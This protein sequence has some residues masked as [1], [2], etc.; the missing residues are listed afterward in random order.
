[1]FTAI[2]VAMVGVYALANFGVVDMSLVWINPTFM[3]AQVVGGFLLGTGFIM[4]GLCPGTSVVSAAS[5]RWDA[6]VTIGGIFAGTSLFAVAVDFVPGMDALYH[7]G[8]MGVSTLPAVVGMPPLVLTLV[9]VVVAGIAFIAAEKI[10]ARFHGRRPEIELA[11]RPRPRM[12][13]ATAATLAAATLLGLG[14]VWLPDAQP[15]TPTIEAIAALDLAE[16][17]IAGDPTLLII[18]VRSDDAGDRTRIPGAYPAPD[19]ETL[20]GLLQSAP[21]GMQVILHGASHETEYASAGWPSRL[22]YAYI[23]G[24]F[25][26][27]SADV[28]RPAAPAGASLEDRER[29]ARQNQIAA[30]FTGAVQAPSAAAPPS[31]MPAGGGAPKKKAGGC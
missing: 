16:R 26:R 15:A 4:S 20:I 22:K 28:L 1:M 14:A 11:P 23:E 2:L 3:W 25:E 27:W 9:V 19:A 13:F 8:D 10:E 17:I 5:G 18:D 6:V 21:A 7:A 29:V 30:W 12:K 24:G 31:A